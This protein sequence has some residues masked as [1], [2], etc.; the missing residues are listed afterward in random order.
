MTLLDEI[1][2]QSQIAIRAF[3][4]LNNTVHFNRTDQ[5]DVWGSIQSVLIASGNVSKILWPSYSKYKDRGKQLRDYLKIEKNN[6]LSSRKF[7]NYFEHFDER[8]EER[9]NH[10][11]S[12]VYIDRQ[13]NPSLNKLFNDPE[14]SCQ[15]GYNTFDNTLIFNGEVL[16]VK[17]VIKSLEAILKYIKVNNITLNWK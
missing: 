13:I 2:L 1:V 4:R 3:D 6:I 15:R 9:F 17:E 11:P 16:D 7:R 10:T 8:V 5:I 14:P 12:G